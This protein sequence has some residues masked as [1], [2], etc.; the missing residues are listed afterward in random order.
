VTTTTEPFEGFTDG[1][2]IAFHKAQQQQHGRRSEKGA[3]I[4]DLK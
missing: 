4:D 1:M 3:A 2:C